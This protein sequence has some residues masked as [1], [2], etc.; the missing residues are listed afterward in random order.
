LCYECGKKDH[1]IKGCPIARKK[2]ATKGKQPEQ[3]IQQVVETQEEP[4]HDSALIDL[5]EEEGKEDFLFG[6]M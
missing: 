2:K 1:L 5:G 4:Q 6:D 3:C